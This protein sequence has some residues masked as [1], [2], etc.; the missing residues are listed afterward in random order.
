M[1]RRHHR[2]PGWLLGAVSSGILAQKRTRPVTEGADLSAIRHTPTP[3]VP[4]PHA[5]ASPQLVLHEGWTTVAA[6]AS[7]VWRSRDLCLILARKDFFVRYR[8]AVFGVLWAVALPALQA[9]VLAVI[10]SRVAKISVHHY[11][12][13]IFSGIVGWTYFAATLGPGATAIVDNAA[14]SSRIYFPRAVLP[15]S[16]CLSNVYTLVISVGILLV[17]APLGGAAAG[18]H[19]LYLL[20]A[21]LLLVML[22]AALTLV[23]SATHVYFR[24]IKYAVQAALLIWFY[25]TPVF[26]PLSKLKGWVRTVIEVNPVTGAVELFHA[27]GLGSAPDLRSCTWTVIWTV[28]LFGIGCILHCRN[29]RSFADLL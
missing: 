1:A 26:Y 14:L 15:L 18:L 27:G 22:T 19:M 6:L 13:F 23:L 12:V 8:R 20:P 25:V 16:T 2:F 21:C 9:G 3:I 29:D 7:D 17:V 24:D 28:A 10:L 4:S 5:E 11:P